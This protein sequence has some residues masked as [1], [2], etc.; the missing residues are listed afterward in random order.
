M[1][2]NKKML[3]PPASLAADVRAIWAV[4]QERRQEAKLHADPSARRRRQAIGITAGA[5][6]VAATVW[7]WRRGA[8]VNL[9]GMAKP[10]AASQGRLRD[11]VA[12]LARSVMRDILGPERLHTG[13]RLHMAR[14]V[15]TATRN[16]ENLQR[17]RGL[18]AASMVLAAT[19]IVPVHP[20]TP[21]PVPTDKARTDLRV[22]ENIFMRPADSMIPKEASATTRIYRTAE[23]GDGAYKW[24]SE[25]VQANVPK[26]E[27]TPPEMK[28][29]VA[30]IANI[31]VSANPAIAGDKN[32][33]MN[34]G[35]AYD[36]TQ[37][38]AAAQ[39][40]GNKHH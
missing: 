39:E 13:K 34:L 37:A 3:P 35:D 23:A 5:V 9:S 29:N 12:P 36:I 26:A 16:P 19:G 7:V 18:V 8:P 17:R 32:H 14:T 33:W 31:I 10:E 40:L 4:H 28:S 2:K 6:G 1:N 11:H 22:S 30:D 21:I 38:T 24:A 27:I 20:E 15:R 25:L